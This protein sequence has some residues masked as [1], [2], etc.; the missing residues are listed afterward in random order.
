MESLLCLLA[1]ESDGS[2]ARP[3]LETL[4]ACRELAEALGAPFDVGLLGGEVRRGADAASG[5]GARRFL[6]AESPGLASARYASDATAACALARASAA[7]LVLAPHTSRLARVAPGVAFRLGGR[8][9]THATEL[10]VAEG[11]VAVTRWYYRQRLEAVLTRAERPWL[12]TLEPGSRAAWSGD[13][14]KAALEPVSV[15][16]AP[17]R[18]TVTGFESPPAEQQTIRPDAELLLVAGA[19]WTKPQGAAGVRAEEAE[20]LILDFLRET[21]ASLGGS[22]SLVDAS[23]EGQ[24]VLRFMTHLN[25]V[26]QTGSTPRH[27]KGLATC[28]HG[29]E[30]HTVGWRFIGERRAINRDPA[31]GWTR[32]KAD[33]VYV[34]DAFE[35]MARVNA[36]LAERRLVAAR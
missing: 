27:A 17:S 12:V 15:E 9:D 35:V 3:A 36:L 31:C 21:R 13:G 14:S 16:D 25:Q 4:A 1:T 10:A 26:G 2:L 30:P 24:A 8:A 7:S 29:E 20:R 32:G 23:G 22:K 34:A 28:C 6:A 18:T 11:E 5:C 33:V 19:G